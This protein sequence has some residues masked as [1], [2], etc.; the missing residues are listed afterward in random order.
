MGSRAGRG[1]TSLLGSLEGIDF[2]VLN[3]ET[4]NLFF[5]QPFNMQGNWSQTPGFIEKVIPQILQW[6]KALAM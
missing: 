6:F 4:R 2:R 5:W 1:K 3:A